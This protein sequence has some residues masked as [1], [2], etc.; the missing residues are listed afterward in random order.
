MLCC[1]PILCQ[2]ACC[3]CIICKTSYSTGH[4][5][6]RALDNTLFYCTLHLIVFNNNYSINN[7]FDTPRVCGRC[8]ERIRTMHDGDTIR[9]WAYRGMFLSTTT[10]PYLSS[11]GACKLH[12]SSCISITKFIAWQCRINVHGVGVSSTVNFLFMHCTRSYGGALLH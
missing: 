8:S 7:S 1:M 2:R 5:T 3:I 12:T 9:K 10:S 6:V 4:K 11:A